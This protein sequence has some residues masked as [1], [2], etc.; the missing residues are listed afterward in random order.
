MSDLRL[1]VKYPDPKIG[2]LMICRHVAGQK[3]LKAGRVYTCQMVVGQFV[4]VAD[5]DGP[6]GSP[7][8][9]SR[10]EKATGRSN[11]KISA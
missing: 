8:R 11:L 10:F 9:M 4:H 3:K 6:L 5:E 1:T 2:E 7:F